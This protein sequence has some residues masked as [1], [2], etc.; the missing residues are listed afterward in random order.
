MKKR[1]GISNDEAWAKDVRPALSE[2]ATLLQREIEKRK[3]ALKSAPKGTLRV[4]PHGKSCQF[5]HRTEAHDTSGTYIKKKNIKLAEALAQKAYSKKFIEVASKELQLIEKYLSE[6]EQ[7][8]IKLI[9]EKSH[10]CRKP[11]ISPV[12][13][14]DDTFITRWED[15]TYEPGYFKEGMPV[16]FTAKGEKVRSKIEVNIANMLNYYNIPYRYEYPIVLGNCERRPDFFCLNKRKRKEI[17]WEHFG[18]MEHA[19]YAVSNVA[20]IN[21]YMENGYKPGNNLIMTFETTESPLSTILIKELIET[22]LI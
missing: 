19:D 12:I 1:E 5:Y 21:K 16:H 20:K 10:K 2:R 8:G 4:I 14:D 17:I 9:Y 15:V 3:E 13:E 22:Y 18:L 11:L 7:D 6:T